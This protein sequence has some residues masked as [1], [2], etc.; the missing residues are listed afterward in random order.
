MCECY[1]PFSLSLTKQK[2][3]L[4]C[5]S[6]ENLF[7]LMKYLVTKV[8]KS[9]KILANILL[10]LKTLSSPNALAYFAPKIVRKQENLIT[11]TP[12]VDLVNILRA[13]LT[14]LAK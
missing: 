4:E 12:V 7:N 13:Q 9:A 11:L 3:I 14:P 2:N 8:H 5:L 6:Q 10:V 1:Q